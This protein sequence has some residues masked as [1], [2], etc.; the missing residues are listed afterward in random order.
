[1]FQRQGFVDDQLVAKQ[2]NTDDIVRKP[3]LHGN[4]ISPYTGRVIYSNP[5]TGVVSVQWPWGV[6]QERA[7]ELIQDTSGDYLPPLYDQSYPT[8]E[9]SRNVNSKPV[10]DA[11]K[12]WRDSIAS[13]VVRKY[14]EKTFPLYLAACKAMSH[15]LDEI[16]AFMRISADLEDIYGSDA[17]RRTVANLYGAG[18]RLAIY[19]KDPKRKYRVTQKEKSSGNLYC[20]RCKGPL[21]PRVY[22][23]G[24][25]VLAC[26]SC[27]FAIH[28]KDVVK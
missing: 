28:P 20:P 25:R 18:K 24:E 19:W 11:D 2:F 22:K 12:K 3:G 10:V 27:G 1:M 16:T 26:K 7:S 17:V 4:I 23:Q 14:E 5:D 15:G 9:K 8:W 6:E 21:K 13:N